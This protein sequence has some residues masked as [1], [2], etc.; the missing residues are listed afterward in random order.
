MGTRGRKSA[1]ELVIANAILAS[2]PDAPYSLTDA[3]AD[4]WRAIVASMQPEYFARTHYPMLSQLCRHIVASNRV[5]QLIESVCRRRKLDRTELTSLLAMQAA[6]TAA[7]VR[8]SRQL[9]LTHQSLYRA[10]SKKQRPVT[11]F[12]APWDQEE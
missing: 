11:G 1:A 3:E 10:D 8:L 9:R 6:E 4:E 12:S 5:A 2:R 7:I